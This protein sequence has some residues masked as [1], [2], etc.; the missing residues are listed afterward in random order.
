MEVQNQNDKDNALILT[1]NGINI[2]AQY[3][4]FMLDTLITLFESLYS[5][6]N[7]G[8]IPIFS[9]LSQWAVISFLKY[10]IFEFPW[11]YQQ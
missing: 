4:G 6:D 11:L 8:I 9:V 3:Y 7:F 1:S 2:N 10:A 5:I